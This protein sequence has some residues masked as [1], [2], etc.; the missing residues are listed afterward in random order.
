MAATSKQQRK[1]VRQAKALW[2]RLR[3]IEFNTHRF[4][5]APDRGA[6]LNRT[7]RLAQRA[8]DRYARL[9]AKTGYWGAS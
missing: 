7:A 8:Y 9:A 5:W 4:Y 3:S 6:R 2:L 1:M